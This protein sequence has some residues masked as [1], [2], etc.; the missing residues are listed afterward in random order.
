MKM[1]TGNWKETGRSFDA[2]YYSI[3]NRRNKVEHVLQQL[4]GVI[5]RRGEKKDQQES[6]DQFDRKKLKRWYDRWEVPQSEIMILD[7]KQGKDWKTG[8]G[9]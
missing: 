3:V 2:E 1:R 9:H 6:I 4:I 5:W 7:V 8:K